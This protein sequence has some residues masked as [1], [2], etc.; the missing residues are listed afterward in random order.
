[1]KTYKKFTD[2][3]HANAPREP[4]TTFYARQAFS[5]D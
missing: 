3:T 1:M 2:E 4:T 5:G